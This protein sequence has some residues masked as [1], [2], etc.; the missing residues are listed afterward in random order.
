MG[1]DF[2]KT[3]T[4]MKTIAIFA[5]GAGSNAKAI[6][7]YLHPTDESINNPVGLIVCNKPEAGVINIAKSHNIPVL[8]IEKERFFNLDGYLEVLIAFNI[9]FIVLAG[10]LWKI[11]DVLINA[12]P[13][14]IINIHPALLPKYGGKG[15]YGA[16]V[17][18][19]VLAANEHES[20][21]SIHFVDN[22]YD[23][24]DLIFQKKCKIDA[25]DTT[26]SLAKKIHQLEHEH[27]PRIVKHL[28]EIN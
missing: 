16:R 8:L 17:H 4:K 23:H 2:G 21:I 15:M 9:D 13:K 19:A 14:K 12:F 3:I 18:E 24:G 25:E 1:K 7:E 20:G 5:S 11:P 10:F 22:Q 27:F 6:I 26:A 28:I